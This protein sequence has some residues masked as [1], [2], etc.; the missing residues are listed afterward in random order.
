[1][2]SDVL[3]SR[4]LPKSQE[5]RLASVL[6]STPRFAPW[7]IGTWAAP[8]GY[9]WT[10]ILQGKI[11]DTILVRNSDHA[12][13]LEVP[14]YTQLV[15]ANESMMA[16]A[17]SA[18]VVPTMYIV[19]TEQIDATFQ[20]TPLKQLEGATFFPAIHRR[21][22]LSLIENCPPVLA[23]HYLFEGNFYV[24]SLNTKNGIF[25]HNPI[26]WFNGSNPEFG[27]ESIELIL[28]DP[29]T[30][31]LIGSGSHIPS[32]VMDSDGKTLLSFIRRYLDEDL[33]SVNE[34]LIERWTERLNSMNSGRYMI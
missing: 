11:P 24:W 27:Y 30:G 22:I 3:S 14:R 7:G 4:F 21:E 26:T 23:G 10:T 25:S 32:F 18:D 31:V 13:V 20:A 2:H 29:I 34:K 1:M 15:F 33:D 5:V 8:K 28:A 6:D 12:A 17:C 19:T 9:S 16:F